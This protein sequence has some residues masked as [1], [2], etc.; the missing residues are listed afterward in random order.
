MKRKQNFTSFLQKY[1]FH[2]LLLPLFFITH[3]YND[4]VGL[5]PFS[6]LLLLLLAAL[7]ISSVI[8]MVSRIW[9]K[10]N[11]KASIFSFIFL[12]LFLFFGAIQDGIEKLLPGNFFSTLTFLTGV[13]IGIMIASFLLIKKTKISFSRLSIYLNLL[14][15][16]LI[17]IDAFTI[18]SK[19]I[20]YQTAENQK[21]NT[22]L[23]KKCDTCSKPSVYLIL[24]DEYAGSSSLEA[25]FNYD[26]SEFEQGLRNEGFDL[27]KNPESNY[28]YT[29]FSIASM[30]TMDYIPGLRKHNPA[31]SYNYRRSLG[32]IKENPVTYNFREQGYTIKNYSYFNIEGFPASVEN[33]FLPGRIHLL[34]NKTMYVRVMD[35]LPKLIRNILPAKFSDDKWEQ[36]YINNNQ[37]LQER[38]LNDSAGHPSFTYVHL[39]MPHEPFAYNRTGERTRRYFRS[40]S[41]NQKEV[42]K[43]YLD[44]LI[45]TNKQITG[46]IR[47]LKEKANGK[48]II[49]LM[50]DHGYRSMEGKID[51]KYL[52]STLNAVYLP[53]GAH[54]VE[55]NT[56]VNQFRILFNKLFHQDLPLLEDKFVP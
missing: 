54:W 24:L 10:T 51:H 12:L 21:L 28:Y 27:I 34:I 5:I 26:N 33:D 20:S 38:V 16:I 18:I 7:A 42:D 52:Y 43:A 56:H 17:L 48:A 23:V 6:D 32:M 2:F 50:G 40:T 1:N 19:T 55:S 31:D 35:R 14:L 49:M 36:V 39:M 29:V 11:E 13:A 53:E 44:Y 45:Y 15:L 47:K 46:F 3:G 22:P 30:F 25:Y 41:K 37:L 8:F 9:M 4:N